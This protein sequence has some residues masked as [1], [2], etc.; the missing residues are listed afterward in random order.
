MRQIFLMTVGFSL[1]G[2]TTIINKILEQFPKRF[3]TIDTR[4]IHDYLNQKYDLFL[5]NN[6]IDEPIFKTRQRATDA[7]QRELLRV[8]IEDGFSIIKDSCNQVR[9][10]RKV[11]FELA[12]S[13]NPEIKTLILYVNPKE[14]ELLKTIAE[15]DN[16]LLEKGEKPAWMDLYEKVQKTR[17]EMPTKDESEYFVEYNRDNEK[18]V[19]E[20]INNLIKSI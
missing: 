2:K 16:R 7:M 15:Y 14:S 17:L 10:E 6:T 8:M 3:F 1:S 19:L 9:E 13:I 12:K 4:S 18:S 20:Q 5:D 11:Q